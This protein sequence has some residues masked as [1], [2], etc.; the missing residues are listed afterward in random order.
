MH[1]LI[2]EFETRVQ[3]HPVPDSVVDDV[4]EHEGQSKH[5]RATTL[6]HGCDHV[7]NGQSRAVRITYSVSGG[8]WLVKTTLGWD[9]AKP[10]PEPVADVIDPPPL[11]D[12]LDVLY[13][14]HAGANDRDH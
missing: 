1:P 8:C 6:H 10:D 7:L 3:I 14:P 13:P 5:L 4:I 2:K 9:L 11:A 12:P